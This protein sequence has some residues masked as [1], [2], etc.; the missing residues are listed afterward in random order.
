MHFVSWSTGFLP[1]L[2][3]IVDFHGI[4]LAVEVRMY[5]FITPIWVPYDNPP[6]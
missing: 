1:R 2:H 6:R 3:C 5:T 4:W